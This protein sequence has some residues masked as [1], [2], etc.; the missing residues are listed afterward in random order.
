VQDKRLKTK[1]RHGAFSS[2]WI[3]SYFILAN[4]LL[5]VYAVLYYRHVVWQLHFLGWLF[6]WLCLLGVTAGFHR[7]WSHKAYSAKLPLRVFLAVIG[8]MSFQGSIKWWVTRHRIHHRFTDTDYDPYNAKRGLWYSHIGWL[9]EKPGYYDKMQLVDISDLKE[10]PVVEWQ[11]KWIGYGYVFLGLIL[12]ASLGYL[13]GDILGGIL[14]LGVMARII[15]W[16]GI[17]ATN[18]LAH[19]YGDQ[20]YSSNCTARGSFICAVICNGEGNH[21]YHHEFPQDWRHGIKWHEWDPTKWSIWAWSKLGLAFDLK[22]SHPLSI[23]NAELTEQERRAKELIEQ[24]QQQRRTLSSKDVNSLLTITEAE[25]VR[26]VRDEGRLWIRIEGF[27]LD[28][29][30]F[31]GKHPGGAKIL[32]A[33]KGKDATEAFNGGLNVHTKSARFLAS[34]FRVARISV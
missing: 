33:Y 12:P 22:E 16:N 32:T 2:W 14:W 25:F 19:W 21:N 11:L 10:D 24:L 3:I 30:E 18:S 6:A 7:L 27:V 23:K 5:A 31:A 1:E 17:W 26:K 29:T 13:Y 28:I 8:T 34:M 20:P 15:S 9:L 4:H